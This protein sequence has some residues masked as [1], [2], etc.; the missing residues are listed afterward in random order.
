M[1]KKKFF[2]GKVLAVMGLSLVVT[3]LSTLSVLADKDVSK[4]ENSSELP[5]T[6]VSETHDVFSRK[7][8]TLAP[9]ISQ[10]IVFAYNKEGSQMAYYVMTADITKEDVSVYANYKDNQCQEFGMEKLTAQLSTAQKKHSN[11]EDKE[12]YIENYNVIGGVNADFYNMTTGKPSGAFV[13]EGKVVNNA[14]NRPWFAVLD[15]GSAAI[16]YNNKDWANVANHVK[17]AVGGSVVLVWDGKDVTANASGNYNTDRHSR[18]CV[19]ITKEGKVVLMVL[20]GRQEPFSAGGSMHELAQIMLEAGCVSAI[21]LDGGGSTTFAAKQEGENNISIVNRPSDGS[22]RSI[23]SSLMV[24]STAVPTDKF[25]HAILSA[26]SDYVTPLSKVNIQAKGV[27]Q[28]GTK[29]NLPEDYSFVL[30][31]ESFGSISDNTFV[32]NGKTGDA[33]VEM[34][35]QGKVVGKTSIHVVIPDSIAFSQSQTTV[36]YGKNAELVINA[37]YGLNQVTVKESDFDFVLENENAGKMNGFLFEATDDESIGSTKVTATLVHNKE[38][39]SEIEVSLGKGSEVIFDF[40]NEE[41]I[42]KFGSGYNNSYNYVVPDNSISRANSQNGKV[43]SGNGALALNI[44][45]STSLE[46]GYQLACLSYKGDELL[47]KNATSFGAWFYIPDEFDAG[48]IRFVLYPVK[49]IDQEGNTTISGSTVTGQILDGDSVSTTGFVSK[50]EESGWHYISCDLSNYKGLS[51]KSNAYFLQFYISDRDGSSFDYY[52]KEHKSLNSKFTFY[53]DDITVDYSSAVADREAPVFSNFTY[54]T[55]NMSDAVELKGQT[56]DSDVLSFNVNLKDNTKKTNYT[57][58]DKDSIKAY[59]DGVEKDF[60]YKNG[61]VALEDVKLSDGLHKIKFSAKDMAGNYN[62]IIRTVNIKADSLENTIKVVAHDKSLNRILLGSTYYVDLVATDI[63]KVEEVEVDLDLNN[64]SVWQLDNMTVAD[65]FEASYKILEDNIAKITI[66]KVYKT[67]LTGETILAFLPIKTWELKM[68]YI[69]ASGNKMGSQALTYAQFKQMKEFWPIDISVEVDRGLVTF[70]DG[71]KSTFSGETV[72]VDTEMW[73][74]YANMNAKEPQYLKEWNGGHIHQA[75]ALEDK[76]ASLTESGYRGRTYCPVCNSIVDWGTTIPKLIADGWHGD[77]YYVNNEKLTGI[78][79]IDGIYYDFGEDGICKDKTKY[80]GLFYDEEV[81]AYRYLQV[82]KLA[83]GW[84]MID[85]EWYYFMPRK[86]IAA[87]GKYSYRGISYCF[88]ETGKLISGV[89]VEFEGSYKYYYGPDYYKREWAN[90]DG[91]KY[92]FDRAGYP[93]KGVHYV[94]ESFDLYYQWYDFGEDG[95]IVRKIEDTGFYK[96]DGTLYFVKDG[97]SEYFGLFVYEGNYYYAKSDYSLVTGK[98]EINKS[99]GLLPDGEYVF[100]ENGVL[101][102][103]GWVTNSKGT[104]YWEN[105]NYSKGWKEIEGNTYYFD[106]KGYMAVGVKVVD[107]ISYIFGDDGVYTN[108][109]FTGFIELSGK[110]YYYDDGVKVTGWKEINGSYYYFHNNAKASNN[111]YMYT[112]SVTISKVNYIFASDGKLTEPGIYTDKKGTRRYLAGEYLKGLQKI[113]DD[114]YYFDE[115]NGYMYKGSLKLG[116]KVYI[117]NEDGKLVETQE[118]EK[119][120]GLVTIDGKTYFYENNEA[121][122]GWKEIEGYYYYFDKNTKAALTGENQIVDKHKYN[123]DAKGVLLSGEKFYKGARGYQY[124]FAGHYV[125][126]EQV[127]DGNTYYFDSRGYMQTGVV[128]DGDLYYYFGQTE[129]VDYGIRLEQPY[130]GFAIFS[131]KKYYI[132]DGI[133]QTGWQVINGNIYYLHKNEAAASNGYIYTGTKKISGVTYIFNT[134][135]INS[136]NYGKL[137][138]LGSLTKKN[139]TSY[140]WYGNLVNGIRVIDTNVYYFDEKGQMVKSAEVNLNGEKLIF[141]EDG[142]MTD[143]NGTVITLGD[144]FSVVAGQSYYLAEGKSQYGW[145][146]VDGEK[147]YFEPMTTAMVKGFYEISGKTYYFDQDGKMLYGCTVEIEGIQYSFADDGV[148]Q[149]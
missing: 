25:D 58:V 119:L 51:L 44:D 141:G 93:Y 57:G 123:F 60:T 126:G 146:E 78:K 107:G 87:S 31:D 122:T 13:M 56:V 128:K 36:P 42:L 37:L 34:I 139:I 149:N 129:T 45:Y 127:I 114:T 10:D 94:K 52:F 70:T 143:A 124:F 40:E 105:G 117:F 41:D 7:T 80:T 112:G 16:G 136:E 35:Y 26:Q 5:G 135:D 24:V 63:S 55:K 102:T 23:S 98:Y 134:D 61:I 84:K 86:Y 95:A 33:V 132:K 64:M 88:E 109:K 11:P 90:I 82:G 121:V 43:H 113:G 111:G 62:S 49:E 79:A 92:Y 46:S 130:T 2:S 72:Q 138:E 75:E 120:N 77:S 106:S 101:T 6:F 116:D 59:V 71:Q 104:Q 15:D 8:S 99:N 97:I 137:E 108:S 85:N 27:S 22:E 17:E 83:S 21:N 47:L 67:E 66:K 19:G 115:T 144:S 4:D 91:K 81:G 142:K 48:W 65:G 131:G 76:E 53:I 32:S 89:W 74:N 20:D 68:N 147:Y 103:G 29:A 73:A 148:L 38:L 96:V 140:Y 12:N 1:K 50:F 54:A 110:T 133:K 9:G 69:Y 125:T 145:L 18:T 118:S 30:E 14:N 3:M 28:V 100:D 39:K